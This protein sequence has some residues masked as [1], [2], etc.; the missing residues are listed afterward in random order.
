MGVAPRDPGELSWYSEKTSKT[1]YGFFPQ[2]L[3]GDLTLK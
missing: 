3:F 2:L 1:L